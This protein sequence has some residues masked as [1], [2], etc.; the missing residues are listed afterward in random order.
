MQSKIFFDSVDTNAAADFDKWAKGK[1]L[2]KDVII[3]THQVFDSR[4][5]ARWTTII[6]IFDE[7]IHPSW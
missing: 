1:A 4:V 5:G 6:V 7:V 2:S 3:H